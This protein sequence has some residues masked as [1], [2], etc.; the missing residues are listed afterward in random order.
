MEATQPGPAADVRSKIRP[1]L[2][3]VTQAPG[4][5][6]VA[7]EVCTTVRTTMMIRRCDE[8]KVCCSKLVGKEMIYIMRS[9]ALYEMV[10]GGYDG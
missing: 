7:C 3:S 10:N 9:N 6:V 2:K 8:K 5:N 4:P 1:Q